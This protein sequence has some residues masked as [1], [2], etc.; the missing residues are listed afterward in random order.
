[1]G[2]SIAHKIGPIQ[3]RIIDWEIDARTIKEY[4]LFNLF[5]VVIRL[6]FNLSSDAVFY[7]L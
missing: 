7:I 4:N 6:K 5:P 1:M 3:R 2:V